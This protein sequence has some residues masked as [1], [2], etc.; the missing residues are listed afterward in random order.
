LRIEIA[1]IMDSMFILFV[2]N[3]VG[4]L[5]EV[6]N[7]QSWS[8]LLFGIKNGYSFLACKLELY[9]ALMCFIDC[10]F[11]VGS[12]ICPMASPRRLRNFISPDTHQSNYLFRL[13]S[14]VELLGG[15]SSFLVPHL[16]SFSPSTSSNVPPSIQKLCVIQFFSQGFPFSLALCM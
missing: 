8:S 14:V 6:S 1:E 15:R 3:S 12:L 2:F 11:Q 16:L 4:S 7:Y 9:S 13:F 10:I 5:L